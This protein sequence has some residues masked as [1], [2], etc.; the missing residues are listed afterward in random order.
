MVDWAYVVVAF[1]TNERAQVLV[2][3]LHAGYYLNFVHSTLK[4]FCRDTYLLKRYAL[5]WIFGL[6]CQAQDPEMYGMSIKL[7]RL[8]ACMLPLHLSPRIARSP[9]R[10][11]WGSTVLYSSSPQTAPFIFSIH[12]STR[13]GFRALPRYLPRDDARPLPSTAEPSPAHLLTTADLAAKR[14]DLEPVGRDPLLVRDHLP[15]P[16]GVRQRW[17][18]LIVV[19]PE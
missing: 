15:S 13:D 18:Q 19:L 3:I 9:H 4:Y 12:Q 5:T 17:F 1:M 2:Q 11:D 6:G 16:I 8:L 10:K 7:T 14:T